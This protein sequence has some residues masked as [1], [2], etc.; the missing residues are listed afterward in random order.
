ML[1][2]ISGLADEGK[3]DNGSFLLSKLDDN[4]PYF[5]LS[6]TNGPGFVRHRMVNE[7]LGEEIPRKD[8]T[9][10]YDPVTGVVSKWQH[11]TYNKH[12]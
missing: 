2:N 9:D 5:A 11:T 12:S 3:L 8:L 1:V 4:K 10:E 7:T 6:Y